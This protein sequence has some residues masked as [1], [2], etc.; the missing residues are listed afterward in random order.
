MY[1]RTAFVGGY[2]FSW[3]NSPCPQRFT[4]YWLV[5]ECWSWS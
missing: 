2:N 3:Y 4:I 5:I 1:Y